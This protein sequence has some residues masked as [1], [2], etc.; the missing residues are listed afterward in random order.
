MVPPPFMALMLSLAFAS[1][2]KGWLLSHLLQ[3]RVINWRWALVI[4][5]VPAIAL[6]ALVTRYLPEWA[7]LAF[8]VPGILAVYFIVVWR[9][10]FGPEDRVL[11]KKNL[12]SRN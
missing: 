7:E 3:A 6:G 8:G 5:A 1:L 9:T 2:I 11:F 10:G 12:G 4:A